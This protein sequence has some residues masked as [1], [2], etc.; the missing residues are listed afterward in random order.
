LSLHTADVYNAK[1]DIRERIT[2]R[3]KTTKGEQ[4]TRSIP[5]SL[6][7]KAVLQAYRSE[8][9]Y[10]FPGRHGLG[11]TP[12]LRYLETQTGLHV[13]AVL[14]DEQINPAQPSDEEALFD[15]WEALA[16]RITPENP[17]QAVRLWRG[18]LS[19]VATED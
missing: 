5:V 19:S 13:V 8:K 17:N 15:E 6:E 11:Y 7:L 9:A 4:S 10:L 16:L 14:K 18:R 3:R 12:Q 2:I 1:G